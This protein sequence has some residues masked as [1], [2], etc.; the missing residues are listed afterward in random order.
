MAAVG[1][2]GSV[3]PS[4]T[5]TRAT[6]SR[7]ADE[8][9]ETEASLRASHAAG[10]SHASGSAGTVGSS[11]E[12]SRGSISFDASLFDM[13]AGPIHRAFLSLACALISLKFVERFC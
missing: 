2:R 7:A 8:L 13:S 6:I 1:R 12:R 9:A 10:W 5:P 11:R 4:C 3:R